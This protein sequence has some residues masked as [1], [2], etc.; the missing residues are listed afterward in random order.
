MRAFKNNNQ[1][2]AEKNFVGFVKSFDNIF[3][4]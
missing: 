3:L 1:F 4:L 2:Q